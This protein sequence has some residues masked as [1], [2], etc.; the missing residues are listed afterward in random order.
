M[1]ESNPAGA[2]FHGPAPAADS[3]ATEVHIR[4][5]RPEDCG[6]VRR[7][8]A[9]TGFLGQPIDPSLKI[10]NCLPTISATITPA[11]NLTPCW[12]VSYAAPSGAI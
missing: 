1:R 9:D 11:A 8:C 10:A 4:A 5:D 3:S 12:C 2:C 6:A 7:I